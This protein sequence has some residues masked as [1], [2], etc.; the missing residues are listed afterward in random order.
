MSFTRRPHPWAAAPDA[1]A[2]STCGT[3]SRDAV[4]GC[5][6]VTTPPP[7]FGRALPPRGPYN[8][9]SRATR[10][11]R[12]AGTSRWKPC[13]RPASDRS[14]WGGRAKGVGR[15]PVRQGTAYRKGAIF[16]WSI[17]FLCR[18]RR[19]RRNQNH[20]P[21]RAS[22]GHSKERSCSPRPAC[23][24]CHAGPGV[25]R[26][27]PVCTRRANRS[28]S[29]V[30]RT[31]PADLKA[32]TSELLKRLG[33]EGRVADD[34]RGWAP[35]DWAPVLLEIRTGE[36]DPTYH[37]LRRSIEILES[38][39]WLPTS[40]R[41]ITETVLQAIGR[42][43]VRAMVDSLP[44]PKTS[45]WESLCAWA[46]P[47]RRDHPG[48]LRMARRAVELLTGSWPWGSGWV[49]PTRPPATWVDE[50]LGRE[51]GVVFGLRT[52]HGLLMRGMRLPQGRNRE[53]APPFSTRS[54]P[55]IWCLIPPDASKAA[56]GGPALGA[57]RLRAGTAPSALLPA[58]R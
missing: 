14:T 30:K 57:S 46:N 29:P 49:E 35:D 12:C 53:R 6:R 24:Y 9:Y 1:A 11:P 13:A 7:C 21:R 58:P 34:V 52:P 26:Y 18:G 37:D 20:I 40:A 43:P 10:T 4:F 55:S 51:A 31:P 44:E 32:A 5:Q 45:A 42:P 36:A 15:L 56:D 16:G 41:S 22:E 33:S 39:P 25:A 3:P 38:Q 54:A 17:P 19:G 8:T 47:Q 50:L 48:R 27:A 23:R 28:S 2:S